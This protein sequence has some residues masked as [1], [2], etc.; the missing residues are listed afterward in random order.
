MPKRGFAV[1]VAAFVLA[2]GIARH[3]RAAEIKVHPLYDQSANDSD[4]DG[5][6]DTLDV[7]NQGVLLVYNGGESYNFKAAMEFSLQGIPTNA[8]VTGALVAFQYAGASGWPSN[9]LRVNGYAGDGQIT[10][11]DFNR[12]PNPVAPLQPAFG[13]GY[14]VTVTPFVRSLVDHHEEYAEFVLE[15]IR[16]NQTSVRSNED[17]NPANRPLL[18]VTFTPIPLP[19]GL[20]PGALLGIGITANLARRRNRR[21]PH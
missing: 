4:L 11:A 14:Y 1:I 5:V 6:W 20:V 10:L 13:P 2:L 21:A 17:P 19:A 3:T 18:W 16:T 8:H 9:T 12:P 15:N 7:P